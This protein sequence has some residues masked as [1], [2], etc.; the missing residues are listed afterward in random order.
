M[1][2]LICNKK[3]MTLIEV[4]IAIVLLTI[5]LLALLSLQSTGYSLAGKSDHLGRAAVIFSE[6]LAIEE[7]RIVYST[8][9]IPTG[10]FTK[11]VYSSGQP[12]AQQGDASYGVEKTITLVRTDV[13][14][15]RVRVTGPGANAVITKKVTFPRL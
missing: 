2:V 13:W 7:A 10:T 3:G 12:A 9:T 15:V 6:E 5:G 14:D 4:M 1:S 11:T 8:D